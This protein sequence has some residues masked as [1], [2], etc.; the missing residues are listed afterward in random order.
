MLC[1]KGNNY[2]GFV[3]ACFP[4]YWNVTILRNPDT[5]GM[6]VMVSTE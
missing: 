4:T 1:G 5:K 2:I 3:K 6:E